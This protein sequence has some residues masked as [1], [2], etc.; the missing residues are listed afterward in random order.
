MLVF[1]LTSDMLYDYVVYL[2]FEIF[3]K[4]KMY[5]IQGDC[6]CE[7]ALGLHALGF[8]SNTLLVEVLFWLSFSLACVESMHA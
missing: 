2:K 5:K 8:L 3:K 7:L 1:L 6:S 4:Y